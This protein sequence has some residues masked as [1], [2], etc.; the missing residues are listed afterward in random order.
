MNTSSK[1]EPGEYTG[2]ELRELWPELYEAKLKRWG[3]HACN[4]PYDWW[5]TVYED[6]SSCPEMYTPAVLEFYKNWQPQLKAG[7][8]VTRAEYE[9]TIE[10]MKGVL[11]EAAV[12]GFDL[13]RSRHCD[14]RFRLDMEKFLDDVKPPQDM[15]LF[16]Q[17]WEQLL[18]T[19]VYGTLS[20]TSGERNTVSGEYVLHA[21]AMM[22]FKELI[23]GDDQNGD[24]HEFADAFVDWVDGWLEPI[25]DTFVDAVTGAVFAALEAEYEYL[26]SEDCFLES[27]VYITEDDILEIENEHA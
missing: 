8:L 24:A 21:D 4:P 12:D 13:G 9:A 11:R 25:I 2:R 19:E 1:L 3:Y 17:V 10:R 18:P 22:F 14:V 27:Y 16:V 7:D 15:P 5:D 23:G 6:F 20:I 26:T